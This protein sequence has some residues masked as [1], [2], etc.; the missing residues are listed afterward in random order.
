MNSV[1]RYVYDVIER[2]VKTSAQFELLYLGTGAAESSYTSGF[3]HID[4]HM[5]LGYALGGLV[6]SILTSLASQPFGDPFTASVLP[7][8]GNT[9]AAP[10][11]KEPGTTPAQP[12]PS[13]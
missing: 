4:W 11:V 5:A 1:T 12:G 7:A 8:E 10:V 2:A 3:W 13:A 6:A 9:P